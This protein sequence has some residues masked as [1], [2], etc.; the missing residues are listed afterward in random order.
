MKDIM[1]TAWDHGINTFDTAEIYANGQSE[2]EMGRVIKELGWNRREL[3]II[4]KVSNEL[5]RV[6][7]VHVLTSCR[8]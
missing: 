8:C 6:C 3:V 5:S 1:Q 2:I 7:H 4:T